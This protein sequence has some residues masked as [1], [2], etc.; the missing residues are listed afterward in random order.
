MRLKLPASGML[1]ARGSE[2]SVAQWRPDD[3]RPEDVLVL[4]A[5]VSTV[6]VGIISVFDCLAPASQA[7]VDRRVVRGCIL[8][9]PVFRSA[10]VCIVVRAQSVKRSTHLRTRSPAVAE[11]GPPFSLSLH[12]P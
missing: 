11:M 9:F 2:Q 3:G 6:E 8:A 1:F 10:T 12:D 5:A 4:E 7:E